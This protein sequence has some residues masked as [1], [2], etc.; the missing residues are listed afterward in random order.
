MN[1]L[2]SILNCVEIPVICKCD[3]R[4]VCTAVFSDKE[5]SNKRLALE[6][7]TLKELILNYPVVIEWISGDFQ[8]ADILTKVGVGNKLLTEYLAEGKLTLF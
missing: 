2:K 4:D 6:V 5:V 1:I 3:N 8:L 7:W